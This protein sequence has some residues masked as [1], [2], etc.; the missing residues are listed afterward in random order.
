MGLIGL[1]MASCGGL[2]GILTRLAKSTDHPSRFPSKGSFKGDVGPHIYIYILFIY[3]D[4]Q[5]FGHI[6]HYRAYLESWWPIIMGY[7]Q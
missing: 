5:Y 6:S 2:Q 7:V 1:I 3:I 4:R